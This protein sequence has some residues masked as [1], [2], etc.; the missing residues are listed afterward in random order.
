MGLVLNKPK[1]GTV[2]DY[3]FGF[4]ILGI[5][6]SSGWFLYWPISRLIEEG[7]FISFKQLFPLNKELLRPFIG[8][9]ISVISIWVSRQL[10]REET[11]FAK[12]YENLGPGTLL[13]I[14]L[15]NVWVI[16]PLIAGIIDYIITGN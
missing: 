5:L 14:L 8:I 3:I 16:F 2:A 12:T 6:I 13:L 7:K 15:L 4:S 1:R 11:W 9:F 10:N